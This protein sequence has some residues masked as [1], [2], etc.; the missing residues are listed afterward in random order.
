MSMAMKARCYTYL[1]FPPGGRTSLEYP[2]PEDKYPRILL[3]L[4]TTK[5]V[6]RKA[7]TGNTPLI[8]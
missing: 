8:E 7:R 5:I 6:Y 4:A 2:S 3:G 1:H